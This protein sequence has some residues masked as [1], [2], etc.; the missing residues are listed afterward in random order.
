MSADEPAQWT[1]L[2]AWGTTLR[3]TMADLTRAAEGAF[4]APGRLARPHSFSWGCESLAHEPRVAPRLP[5]GGRLAIT[6][7]S[8]VGK[9]RWALAIAHAALEEGAAVAWLDLDASFTPS[10]ARRCGIHPED[11]A[12]YRARDPRVEAAFARLL[13]GS[14]TLDLLIIDGAPADYVRALSPARCALVC[15]GAGGREAMPLGPASPREGWGRR[16][17]SA[18]RG[19]ELHLRTPGRAGEGALRAPAHGQ[20]IEASLHDLASGQ[21]TPWRRQWLGFDG[22]WRTLA[23]SPVHRPAR[24]NAVRP[25]PR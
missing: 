20:V 24:K 21:R 15:T 4:G 3:A 25:S 2:R 10:W 9:T 23:H 7:E 8:G 17:C 1:A 11:L 14:R 19:A 6:G 12:V 16:V 18:S 22:S 13:A 5:R